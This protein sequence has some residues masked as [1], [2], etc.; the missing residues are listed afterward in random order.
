M[1]F[2]KGIDS[3]MRVLYDDRLFEIKAVVDVD[4]QH[5]E[6]CL[7]RGAIYMAEVTTFGIQEAIQRFEALGRSVKQLK[8]QH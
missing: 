6:T 2:R 3:K 1:R 7:V 4:E 8:T 5:Q